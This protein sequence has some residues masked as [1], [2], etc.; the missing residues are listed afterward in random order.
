MYNFS[1]SF[2]ETIKT[3]IYIFVILVS[4]FIAIDFL[5]IFFQFIPIKNFKIWF[6]NTRFTQ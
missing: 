4:N 1:K 2:I 5:E 6:I 3:A